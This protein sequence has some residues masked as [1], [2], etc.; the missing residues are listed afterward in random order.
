MLY[1]IDLALVCWIK[2][3]FQIAIGLIFVML[4]GLIDL[5]SITTEYLR[6][7]KTKGD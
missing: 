7:I 4:A 3:V 1:F 2:G 6:G 5:V